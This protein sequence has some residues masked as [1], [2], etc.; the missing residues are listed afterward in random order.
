[1][2]KSAVILAVIFSVLAIMTIGESVYIIYNHQSECAEM[3]TVHKTQ[4]EKDK[5]NG[6]IPMVITITDDDGEWASGTGEDGLPYAVTSDRVEIG[7]VIQA[8]VN[9][10]GEIFTLKKIN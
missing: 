3:S 5:E 6:I 9:D 8:T 2:K 10:E 7:D 4:Q 1:M